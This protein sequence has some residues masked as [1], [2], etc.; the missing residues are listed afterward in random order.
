MLNAGLRA[1]DRTTNNNE[2]IKSAG[3]FEKELS[4]G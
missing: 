3:K 2:V 1:F 4:G